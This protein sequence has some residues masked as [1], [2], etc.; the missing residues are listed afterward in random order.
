MKMQKKWKQL[1]KNI[2]H[3]FVRTLLRTEISRFIKVI[4]LIRKRKQ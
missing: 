1:I 4:T 2:I 3:S